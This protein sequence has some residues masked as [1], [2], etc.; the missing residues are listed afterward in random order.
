MKEIKTV[1]IYGARMVAM[2]VYHAV[3]SLYKDCRV[4]AF[5]VTEAKG[6]LS[7]IDGKPVIP[8]ENFEQKDICILIAAQD[9][10]QD[11]I[12]A[13]LEQKGMRNYIRIDAEREAALMEKYYREIEHLPFLHTLRKG[14]TRADTAVYCSRFH[15]DRALH[16][17]YEYPD[18][19]YPIQAGAAL[20]DRVIADIQD[21]VGENISKKNVNYS[22]LT[23]MYWI[24]KHGTAEYLGLFHY[25]RMLN[26]TD[27]D[28]YRL[29]ENDIDAVLSYP[30]VYYPDILSH[31]RYYL[32]ESDWDAMEKSLRELA[33][34]YAQALPELFQG[35]Y[36]FNH[37]IL[38]AKKK[39]F[40]DY[41]NWLF[42]ILERTEE[43]STPK[44][45]E[46]AD[47]YAGYLG[48]NLMTLYF[49]YHKKDLQIAY[50]GRRMLV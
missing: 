11:E 37:N 27:E 43:Q 8:L 44:G 18:W 25:R 20:T 36:F 2:S 41:C 10:Y 13:S 7:S 26:I 12:A 34:E 17:H 3:K 28:L 35:K 19:M 38:I 49:L 6:N 50:T 29:A 39:V 5:L 9:N 22:E 47:R 24:G 16:D 46:R 1:A 48:E 21:H 4:T 45:W 14:E 42:P 32:P 23:S 15:R 30:A 33:P 40:Q 31:H